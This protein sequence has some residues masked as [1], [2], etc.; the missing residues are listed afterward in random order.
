MTVSRSDRNRR[1][2]F[3]FPFDGSKKRKNGV[4]TPATDGLCETE[5]SFGI[6]LFFFPFEFVL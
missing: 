2:V 1:E 4:E 6:F 3:V 5:V